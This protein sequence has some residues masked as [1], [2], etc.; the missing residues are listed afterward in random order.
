MISTV[1]K[2][3]ANTLTAP[4]ATCCTADVPVTFAVGVATFALDESRKVLSRDTRSGTDMTWVMLPLAT[5]ADNTDAFRIVSLNARPV[6]A[7]GASTTFVD[8]LNPP[9]EPY[10]PNDVL[11]FNQAG[12]PPDKP[13]VDVP[14]SAMLA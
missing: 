6:P 10:E 8:V 11:V 5:Y 9:S 13:A 1:L 3:V 7:P 2:S 4:C 14:L 12:N